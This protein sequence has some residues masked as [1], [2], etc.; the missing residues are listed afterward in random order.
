M[1]NEVKIKL[2]VDGASS[3]RGIRVGTGQ[4]MN[5]PNSTAAPSACIRVSP[6][7]RASAPKASHR[8][9]RPANTVTVAMRSKKTVQGGH[10][11]ILAFASGQQP[12]CATR[13]RVRGVGQHQC[14]S[15]QQA[16]HEAL[17]EER[18]QRLVQRQAQQGQQAACY[19]KVE[20]ESEGGHEGNRSMRVAR[21]WPG[22]ACTLLE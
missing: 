5:R 13:Y 14:R 19:G 17:H 20:Y 12:A 21:W 22:P 2:S 6:A 9:Y 8:Q 15:T 3:R 4:R 7:Q 16:Q 11:R 10:G 18:A 1:A